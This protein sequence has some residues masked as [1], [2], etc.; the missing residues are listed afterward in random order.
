MYPLEIVP[1]PSTMDIE[2]KHILG[3]YGRDVDGRIFTY[4]QF[5]ADAA[6]GTIVEDQVSADLLSAAA[7][8]VSANS[9]AGSRILTDAAE[10]VGDDLR[11]AL[12]L[13]MGDTIANGLGQAFWVRSHT[14]DALSVVVTYAFVSNAPVRRSADAG[15]AIALVAT[16]TTYSLRIPGRVKASAAQPNVPRGIVQHS[17]DVSEAAFGWALVKGMGVVRQDIDAA[18]A[19]VPV[20]NEPLIAV[21]GGRC[22]GLTGAGTTADEILYQVGAAIFGNFAITTGTD[23]PVRYADIDIPFRSVSNRV[24]INWIN[25]PFVQ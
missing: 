18:T 23:D 17:V 13:T 19:R 15:W 22:A 6:P 14:D 20:V 4:C 8:A 11:G 16:S 3:S 24:P 12:G 2:Q 9:A 10:F 25:H 21:G 7:P 5:T 1:S